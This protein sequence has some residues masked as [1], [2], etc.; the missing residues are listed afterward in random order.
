[1]IDQLPDAVCVEPQSGPPNG[2]NDALG[3]AIPTAAPASF[4]SSNRIGDGI[5]TGI[6]QISTVADQA[7]KKTTQASASAK[8][9]EQAAQQ[10]AEAIEEISSLAD[11]L[12]SNN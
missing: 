9:Q 1:M 5:S 8:Q 11:S 2:I 3:G 12:Q 7:E 10:L 4:S 6:G